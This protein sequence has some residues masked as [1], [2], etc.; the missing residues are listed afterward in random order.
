MLPRNVE[1]KWSVKSIDTKG[2][3]FE[4]I[5]IKVTSRDGKAPLEG[6]AISDARSDFGQFS[7]NS[8]V[9]MT[10]NPEGARTWARL[11]KEN[12]G[13]S[14][15]IVLDDMVYSYPNVNTEITGGRS[16]ISGNFTVEEAKD[17][18]NVLKSG[19]M[20]APSRIVQEDVVG[21]SLGQEAIQK[22][23]LSFA[24]AFI[25]VMLYMILMYGVVPGLVVDGALLF[26]VFFLVG[27]LAS[28]KA[29][30]TLPGIAG[31]VLTL[32]M[33]VDANVLIYERIKEELAAGKTHKSAI[34]DG[35]KNALSAILDSNITT[36][37]TA[38]IYFILVLVQ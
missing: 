20:P 16:E 33:A 3:F 18:A 1:F 8:V 12:I 38:V 31:I 15:A 14:I 34:A 4:L 13:R 9:S 30:L 21:P 23:L 27:I 5:A 11:T 28:F 24:I 2:N 17:L 25:G 35:Y 29:V 22:G 7:S 19:R 32:G 6:S 37:I 26:N 10:M 36:I